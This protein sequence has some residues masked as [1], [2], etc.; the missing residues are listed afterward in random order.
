MAG[1]VVVITGTSYGIGRALAEEVARLGHTVAGCGRSREAIDALGR[2][3]GQHHDFATVDV[4]S[5]EQVRAWAARVIARLGAPDL[6]VNN[7]ALT[8]RPAPLWEIEAA[9]FDAVID[10]NV[11]GVANTIRHFAPPMIERGRGVIVN[12]SS[13]YG[14]TTA[15]EVA[16]YCATKFAIEGLT[17]ALAQELPAGLAAIPL[18]PGVIDTPMLRTIFGPGAAHHEGPEAWAKRAAPYIL[19][20]GPRENGKSCR[21]P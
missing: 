3:L 8:N 1:K 19:S 4:A 15:P 5:D 11:K 18:S 12:L 7:A 20:L 16:P 21:V 17:K 14:H 6:L 9:D 13:G 10:V 2:N